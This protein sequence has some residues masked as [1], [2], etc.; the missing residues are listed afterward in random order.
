MHSVTN[1]VAPPARL[2]SVATGGTRSLENAIARARERQIVLPTL[3]QQQTPDQTPSV[4]RDRLAR[5]D[6]WALDPANLFRITWQNTPTKTGGGF[7][8]VNYLELPSALTGVQA[9]IIG[10]VGKHFPTGAHKVGAAYGC[11]V[12]RLVA[13]EFD[14]VNQSAV[15]PSTGN[16]CRGGAYDSAL[17]GCNSIAILPEGMSA[18]RFSWLASLPG[19]VIKTPGTESNVKEIF[20]KCWEL[21]NSGDDVVIFNQFD[22]PGNYLWH[23]TVTGHA[24]ELVLE[25]VSGPDSKYQGLVLTTGSAGTIA[26]GDYLKQRFPG[27]RLVAAEPLQCPTMLEAGYGSHRIEG[28]GDKH[29]P[30]IHNARNLDG[31][32]AV[33]D[34]AVMAVLRLFNEP[35]GQREL[36]RS[37]V[38]ADVIVALKQ[39][40]ISGIAN[41]LAC[42]KVAKAH[43]LGPDDILLTVFTDSV[44]MYASRVS[45]LNTSL[46]EFTQR[47]AAVVL[48]RD[49]TS[50]STENYRELCESGRR[51]IHNMKYFTWVE[52]QGKAVE[53]LDLQW[54]DSSYWTRIQNSAAEL[55]EQITEFNAR[56][57]VLREMGQS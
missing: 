48:A 21:R 9:R 36:A 26:A 14:P 25:A 30:W 37:G 57:G 47:D 43:S 38:A 1:P 15:W 55:D 31:I 17:L 35:N 33:D 22:E 56:T 8:G 40:G 4:I 46:G 51:R 54:N 16:Y 28:V 49:L 2:P 52:Q 3:R 6:L 41:I 45:E 42:A 20:D 23:V 7:G 10:L 27:S 19:R 29:I 39:I 32:A 34:E 50:P 5:L 13:G 53:E 12:P 44:D 11:L 18:E 24:M